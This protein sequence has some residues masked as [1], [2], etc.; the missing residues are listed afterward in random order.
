MIRFK[1]GMSPLFFNKKDQVKFVQ[2]LSN[3]KKKD[4]FEEAM[5][6]RQ[7]FAGIAE[8][9]KLYIEKNGNKVTDWTGLNLYLPDKNMPGKNVHYYKSE[10]KPVKDGKTRSPVLDK[11]LNKIA[12]ENSPVNTLEYCYDTDGD[13]SI[14][15]N[16]KEY[17]FIDD[18]AVIT[19]ADYIEQQIKANKKN[20]RVKVK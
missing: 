2:S 11:M 9:A 7:I 5:K 14:T 17:L 6:A 12:K 4:F 18:E 15:V 13:F 16:G 19:I 1:V 8:S 3:F 20:K 10:Y